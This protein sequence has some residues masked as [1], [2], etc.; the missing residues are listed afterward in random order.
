MWICASIHMFMCMLAHVHNYIVKDE[1]E[2]KKE[3][4]G[5]EVE[6]RG[7][8]GGRGG[9]HTGRRARKVMKVVC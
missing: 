9:G 1:Q 4:E 7:V 8:G 2:R 3:N 5:G 6:E